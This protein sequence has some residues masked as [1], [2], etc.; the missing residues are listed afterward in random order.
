M[1]MVASHL[2]A[3][4]TVLET[5]RTLFVWLVDLVRCQLSNRLFCFFLEWLATSLAGARLPFNCMVPWAGW[6]NLHLTSGQL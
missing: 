5:T 2:A 6:D 1:L 3:R 4:R